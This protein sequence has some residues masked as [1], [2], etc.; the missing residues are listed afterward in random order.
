MYYFGVSRRGTMRYSCRT[1]NSSV[2]KTYFG[3]SASTLQ[4]SAVPRHF[5][6]GLSR[7]I[8]YFAWGKMQATWVGVGRKVGTVWTSGSSFPFIATQLIVLVFSPNSHYCSSQSLSLL[9]TSVGLTQLL[10]QCA[11]AA[12]SWLAS[13]FNPFLFIFQLSERC[14]LVTQSLA[15]LCCFYLNELSGEMSQMLVSSP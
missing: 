8:W 6:Q 11:L 4:A 2:K 10:V 3:A 12:A 7:T 9:W 14:L 13:S 15:S 1:L 5:V